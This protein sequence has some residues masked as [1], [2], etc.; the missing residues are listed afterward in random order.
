MLAMIVPNSRLQ[1]LRSHFVAKGFNLWFVGGCVRDTVLGIEPKDV[2]LCTDATPEEQLE[3]Y[4][5]NKIRY[6]E[7][8]I[9]HGTITVALR[10][11][12]KIILPSGS[13]SSF[14]SYEITSL[15]T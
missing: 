3:I 4:R 5:S 2:D 1:K 9:K 13:R 14:E 11:Q 10:V 12:P 15:R 6:F 8:G 7:T